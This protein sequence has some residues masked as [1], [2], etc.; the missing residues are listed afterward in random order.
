MFS[1]GCCSYTGFEA[2]PVYT[3]LSLHSVIQFGQNNGKLSGQEQH[4]AF[5]TR[6]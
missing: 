3:F 2:F 6:K 1:V 4:T 5:G